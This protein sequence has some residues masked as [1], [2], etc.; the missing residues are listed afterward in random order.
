MKSDIGWRKSFKLREILILQSRFSASS[1]VCSISLVASLLSSVRAVCMV[2]IIRFRIRILQGFPHKHFWR[3]VDWVLHSARCSFCLGVVEFELPYAINSY[4]DIAYESDLLVIDFLVDIL[5]QFF[6][7]NYVLGEHCKINILVCIYSLWNLVFFLHKL[8]CTSFSSNI[9]SISRSA[10]WLSKLILTVGCST[11]LTSLPL[12]TW[13]NPEFS[14]ACLGHRLHRWY[15]RS[16]DWWLKHCA[17][18]RWYRGGGWDCYSSFCRDT[19]YC[20]DFRAWE[21]SWSEVKKSVHNRVTLRS[22]RPRW[23]FRSSTF[24]IS[25]TWYLIKHSVNR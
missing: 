23:S 10:S 7:P 17:N 6:K 1:T 8:R 19:C 3:I 22:D 5:Q 11:I 21:V 4:L 15:R 24:I 2:F 14:K 13:A 9:F 12:I 20:R 16:C 25:N 18:Q